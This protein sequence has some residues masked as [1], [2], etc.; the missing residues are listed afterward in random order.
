[1]DFLVVV[2]V[3][4]TQVAQVLTTDMGIVMIGLAL[5]A[6][7]NII[8]DGGGSKTVVEAKVLDGF[9]ADGLTSMPLL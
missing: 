6:T 3:E 2:P 1:M 4:H 7:P 8:G 9:S 5:H